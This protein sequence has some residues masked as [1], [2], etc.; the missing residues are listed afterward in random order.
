MRMI[1][2]GVE[3]D[4]VSLEGVNL[5]RLFIHTTYL[6]KLYLLIQIPIHYVGR[7]TSIG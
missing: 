2:N 5:F 4:W 1:F 7:S 3:G 6:E